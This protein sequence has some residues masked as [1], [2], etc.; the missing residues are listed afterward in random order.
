MRLVVAYDGAPFHGFARNEGVTTVAGVLEDHLARVLGHP[1]RLTAAGRTDAGVHAWGQVVTFDTTAAAL[2]LDRLQR[3]TNRACGPAIVVREASEVGP[4]VDARFSATWRRYRYSVLVS[5]TPDPFLAAT[6]WHVGEPLDVEAMNR[7]GARLV[8][9][10]DF[11]SFCRRPPTPPGRPPASLERTV[12]AVDWREV[13]PELLRLEITAAAFCHQMVRSIVGLLVAVGR[14]RR[15][16]EDVDAALAAAD[17][18]VVP[19][20]APPQGLCL[21]EV[22]YDGERR[23]RPSGGA[24]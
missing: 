24:G 16:V 10:H 3:S 20:L 13:S 6:T 14:G 9:R 15:S 1:V 8:G 17:R 11:S 12:L 2:D 23:L 4:D 19:Q 18:A 22:G 21:W 5:P 7:A